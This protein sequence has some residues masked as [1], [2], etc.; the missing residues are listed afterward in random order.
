MQT[1]GVISPYTPGAGVQP[2][3]LVGRDDV[4]ARAGELLARTASFGQPGRSPLVL[5][6][7]WGTGK[8]VLLVRLV[9]EASEQGFV[10]LQV[11]VDRHG[12][13]VHRVA[14]AVAASM[15]PLKPSGSTRWQRWLASLGRLSVELTVLG[16]RVARPSPS[17]QT[18]DRAADRD[19]LVDLVAESARQAR[20]DR[21]GLLLAFDEL[22]EGPEA[23]LA[24]V[25]AIAQELA[26][27]P[28]VVIGAGLPQTPDRLRQAGSFAERFTYQTLGPLTWPQATAALLVPA[29]GR[30]VAW[31]QAAAEYV[32]TAAAGS[33]FLLQLY[34]DAVWR[35]AQPGPGTHLDLAAAQHGV[36]AAVQELHDGMFRGRWNRASAGEQQYLAAMAAHLAADGT[37]GT[38]QVAAA[39]GRPVTSVSYARSRLLDKGLIQAAGH[40]RI[41]FSMP[42][43][44]AFVNAE[45]AGEQR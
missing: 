18:P 45:T 33:P 26:A 12:P 14:S 34:G 8:T 25:G 17:T 15:A 29:T 13:L 40:G 41:A 38:G 44:E 35:A 7:V 42:G 16:V 37:V 31:E 3:L 1:I 32:L 2:P 5:T 11:T 23:D 22:Q 39:L 20:K 28:V 21:P 4:R 43:F 19:A 9:Q 10:C 24:V 30:G 6:G 36:R 27:E